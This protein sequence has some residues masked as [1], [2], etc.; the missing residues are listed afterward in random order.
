MGKTRRRGNRSSQTEGRAPRSKATAGS[1]DTKVRCDSVSRTHANLQVATAAGSAGDVDTDGAPTV[2][3]T[4]SA[5][6]CADTVPEATRHSSSSS[7]PHADSGA[8]GAKAHT[9]A[10][11]SSA[12]ST[13]RG[14][15]AQG[16]TG[17]AAAG[18][19]ASRRAGEERE[20]D[21]WLE[22]V[23]RQVDFYFSDANLRRDKFMQRKISEGNGLVALSTILQFNRIR[24]LRCRYP[25][26]LAQAIRK[27]DM[28]VLSEDKTKV[29]RDLS[30]APAEHVDPTAR[31]VYIEGLPLT[32][33]I[34]D[35]AHYLARHGCVR[36]VELPH[37]KQTREPRGFCFVEYSKEE[38]A[39]AAVA[40]L[41]GVWPSSWPTRYDG[42]TLRAM[43]KQRWLERKQEYQSLCRAARNST[44]ALALAA[45]GSSASRDGHV[46]VH[47]GGRGQPPAASTSPATTSAPASS[48]SAAAVA[49]PASATVSV[50]EPVP[51]LVSAPDPASLLSQASAPMPEVLPAVPATGSSCKPRAKRGCLLRLSGFPQSQTVLSIRQFAEHAV[52]VEYC[53]FTQ[54]DGLTAHL[55]LRCREDC[56]VLVDDLRRSGRMLGWLRPQVH[57]LGPEEEEEYWRQVD[58]RRAARDVAEARSTRPGDEAQAS[59][60]RGRRRALRPAG[61]E[62]NPQGVVC[63]GPTRTSTVRMWPFRP[64]DRRAGIAAQP[65]T[66]SAALI[67]TV[68]GNPGFVAAGFGRSRRPRKRPRKPT[69][70]RAADTEQ[71]AS[72]KRTASKPPAD[73][74]PAKVPRPAAS[75]RVDSPAMPPP[76]PLQLPSGAKPKRK[77]PPRIPP[78]A[79][80]SAVGPPRTPVPKPAEV[81]EPLVPPPSPVVRQPVPPSP[82]RLDAGKPRQDGGNKADPRLPPPSPVAVRIKE[83]AAPAAPAGEERA[84]EDTADKGMDSMLADTDDILGLLDD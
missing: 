20:S 14:R 15:A 18:H 65:V 38:E 12:A 42:R 55:R 24:G 11:A 37:H 68:G 70:E 76:S 63:G 34:D 51:A 75:S 53:D 23:R 60:K 74:P 52:P 25:A 43:P 72:S 31:T 83:A 27:S 10:R 40:G 64:G 71:Q 73:E 58:R 61:S 22:R 16:S 82:G 21:T 54:P 80:R 48:S 69:G 81:A 32:F 29:Q 4:E 46:D 67:D 44:P 47:G 78:P 49:A 57:I 41:D 6:G 66:R 2:P 9:A 17:G 50:P 56:Q 8:H 13:S 28:L 3:A 30:K 59:P 1:R 26:Q 7:K 62:Q 84:Q 45:A 19:A 79:P 39:A 36:L 35:L 77:P 33:G 5:S